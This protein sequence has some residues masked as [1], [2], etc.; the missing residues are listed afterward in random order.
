MLEI[1]RRA[2][3]K[4]KERND[5]LHPCCCWMDLVLEPL[6]LANT[7]KKKTAGAER[8]SRNRVLGMIGEKGIPIFFFSF[9]MP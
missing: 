1:W 7:W 3:G 8:V 2:G 9:Q 5:V 6:H 4:E